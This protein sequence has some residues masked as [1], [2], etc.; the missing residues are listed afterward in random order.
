MFEP[1]GPFGPQF[2]PST[3]GPGPGPGAGPTDGPPSGPPPSVT[4]QLQVQQGIGVQAIDP[5]SI[6]RCRYRFVYL[7]LR[8]GRE[9]W[10]W[11]TFVGRRSVS[12]WRWTGFRWVYFGVDLRQ[13][14]SFYCY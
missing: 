2:P 11:L 13:I 4:P 9:F 12:G 7:Q 8:N 6:R 5:G 1:F 10:V 14:D 3:G